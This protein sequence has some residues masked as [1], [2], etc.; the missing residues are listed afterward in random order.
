MVLL[1][2]PPS[3]ADAVANREGVA[4][5]GTLSAGFAYPPHTLAV[6][7]AACR[8]AGLAAQVLDAVAERLNL[9]A[10]VARIQ[11]AA[12]DLLAVLTSHTT[13]SADAAA[14][15]ALR[16][17]FPAL[18]VVAI[19]AGARFD[20]ALLLA[21]GASHV[22]LGDPDLALARLAAAPLPAPGPVRVRDLLPH[23]HNH[24]GLVRDPGLL[25][26]PAWDA[27]PWQGYG[28]LSLFSARGCDDGCTFCAYVAAQGRSFRPRAVAQVVDE[29]LWLQ[30]EFRPRRIMVRD[31]VFAADRDRALAIAHQLSAASFRTAWECESRPEHFDPTLL[32]AMA[33][34]ACTVIKLGIETTDPELLVKLGRITEAQESAPYLAYAR[35]VIADARRFGIR[36]RVFVLAGLP[37]Q[38]AAHARATAAFLRQARPDFIHPRPYTSYP[39]VPLGPAPTP[40]DLDEQLR[41]LEAVAAECQTRSTRR[42]SLLRRLLRS[43]QAA[44]LQ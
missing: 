15:G 13:L 20:A 38:T 32:A 37:G 3:P 42:P 18:P 12:P 26:R 28:F 10:T 17:A 29:M 44:N 7:A 16:Q 25:P 31:L 14:L 41:W 40:P 24:A 4:G 1:L 27:V 8:Q 21:A 22:L 5:F 30:G 39:H 2:N 34:A 19:G 33:K 36:T 11:A 23:Q 9:A 6:V 35:R 43:G